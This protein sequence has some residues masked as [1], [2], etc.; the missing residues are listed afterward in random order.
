MQQQ[1]LVNSKTNQYKNIQTKEQ[2]EKGKRTTKKR[3]KYI[4]KNS[5]CN[6]LYLNFQDEQSRDG[7][8]KNLKKQCPPKFETDEK[9]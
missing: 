4:Q 2:K 6:I 7:M 9:D 1:R 8:G 3:R 5:N